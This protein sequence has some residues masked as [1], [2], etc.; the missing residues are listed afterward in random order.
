MFRD[1][2]QAFP[3]SEILENVERLLQ[4]ET[5]TSAHIQWPIRSSQVRGDNADFDPHQFPTLIELLDSQLSASSAILE[6]IRAKSRREEIA[7]DL[8]RD[9]FEDTPG[10][11]P[12]R[13]GPVAA[14]L[15]TTALNGTIQDVHQDISRL[16]GALIQHL[17]SDLCHYPWRSMIANLESGQFNAKIEDSEA[18]HC[19]RLFLTNSHVNED[20]QLDYWWQ[21]VQ[22]SID[23]QTSVRLK[24]PMS[25]KN[26][27]TAQKT[28]SM[29]QHIE[30]ISPE[31]P[32]RTKSLEDDDLC[33]VFQSRN[34]YQHSL[35]YSSCFERLRPCHPT[36]KFRQDSPSVPLSRLIGYGKLTIKTKAFLS[37]CLV[38]MLWQAYDSE[39]INENWS[40]DDIQFMLERSK[41]DVTVSAHEPFLQ[42]YFTKHKGH[43]LL[44]CTGTAKSSHNMRPHR[45]PTLLALGIMLLEIELDQSIEDLVQLDF[46]DPDPVNTKHIMALSVLGDKQLWPPKEIYSF[47][48]E[49][50]ELCVMPDYTKLEKT[51]DFRCNF[52]EE[53]V[54]PFDNF[55]VEAWSENHMTFP[56]SLDA[57]S[58]AFCTP[59]QPL[60]IIQTTMSTGQPLTNTIAYTHDDYTVAWITALEIEMA[61]AQGMLDEVHRSLYQIEGDT[62]NYILGRLGLHKVVI[63][64][65]PSVGNSNA[66]IVAT[67]LLRSFCNVRI[68]LMVGIGGGV[69]AANDMRLGD[70]VVSSPTATHGRM[71][72]SRLVRWLQ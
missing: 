32:S 71:V 37:S 59:E 54:Q 19:F 69:P 18:P 48:R 66:A 46:H 1:Y 2:S 24:E 23:R 17:R 45:Y 49:V 5:D 55:L 58:T 68:G 22:L 70:I 39:W 8:W 56:I 13:K 51:E 26:P 29:A 41:D 65:L 63:A 38:R 42:T 33:S 47:L 28:S 27:I 44:E 34:L 61:V 52:L 50:I 20:T 67:N 11:V 31:H 25:M 53:V 3:W 7:L 40:K 60:S 16:H 15:K 72:P 57:P 10:S 30:E 9:L 62:N 14:E 35:T 64:C 12:E 36:R 6:F 21:D 43:L 4:S